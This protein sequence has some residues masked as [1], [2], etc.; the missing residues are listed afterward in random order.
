MRNAR[1][2]STGKKPSGPTSN[3][4]KK[5]IL[6]EKKTARKRTTLARQGRLANGVPMPPGAIAADLSKQ[7]PKSAF[8]ARFFYA[9]VEFTCNDCGA[10]EVWTA[11]QQK[12]YYEVARGT[13]YAKP[14]RCRSCRNKDRDKKA[15]QLRH[16]QEVA[17]AKA[18][19]RGAHR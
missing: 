11:K 18:A 10:E 16:M 19:P 3:K 12:W 15:A 5:K 17:Q 2:A 9:D 8:S 6:K 1:G 4:R 14:V 13:I 7:S